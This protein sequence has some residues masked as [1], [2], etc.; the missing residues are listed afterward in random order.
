MQRESKQASKQ[1]NPSAGSFPK[2]S[3]RSSMAWAKV[4]SQELKVSHMGEGQSTGIITAILQSIHWQEVGIRSWRHKSDPS[5]WD[6]N[7]L[8]AKHPLLICFTSIP[9]VLEAGK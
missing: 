3:Q 2:L 7:V 9:Q 4:G 6:T 8:I 1:V 5:V